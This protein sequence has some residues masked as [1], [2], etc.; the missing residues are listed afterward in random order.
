MLRRIANPVLAAF[1]I[2]RLR[3][4]AKARRGYVDLRSR[5]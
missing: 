3:R 1:Q 4:Q 2:F 5:G